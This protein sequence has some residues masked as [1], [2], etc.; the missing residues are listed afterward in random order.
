MCR[1][2]SDEILGVTA[3][4]NTFALALGGGIDAGLS[5]SISFRVAQVDYLLTRFGDQSQNNVR[6]ST[7]IVLR[8]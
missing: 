1:R 5:D 3:S 6:I 4:E 8:F 7:G 2:F